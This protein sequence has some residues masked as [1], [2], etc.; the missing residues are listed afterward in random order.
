MVAASKAKSKASKRKS[1]SK[2]PVIS[3][4]SS[5][6]LIKGALISDTLQVFQ[7]WDLK[8]SKRDNLARVRANNCIRAPTQAWLKQ[9][10]T[11][12]SRRFDPSGR[13][14]PLALAAKSSLGQHQW[15]PLLLW[16]MANSETLLGDSLLWAWDVSSGGGDQLQTAQV[17]EW[18][19]STSEAGHPEVKTWSAN[20]QKTR[21]ERPS[22]SRRRL[23]PPAGQGETPIFRVLLSR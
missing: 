19:E 6:G 3:P 1:K 2:A 15:K 18:L 22:E 10:C 16:H 12:F 11:T 9:V 4:Y 20:T 21:G 14:K 5:Y 23:R 13:D 17:L 8:L 7:G